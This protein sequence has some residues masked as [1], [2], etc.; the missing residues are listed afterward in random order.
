[1]L[2]YQK[3]LNGSVACVVGLA[4][5]VNMTT[6]VG[7]QNATPAPYQCATSH[8]ATPTIY[9]GLAT[10]PGISTPI[11]SDCLR[12]ALDI[13]SRAA[14]PRALRVTVTSATEQPLQDVTVTIEVR[15][16]TMD[17]GAS[18]Y[19]TIR[20]APDLF[21]VEKASMGMAGPWQV[22]VLIEQPDTTTV[23]AVFVIEMTN[24]A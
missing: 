21:E 2:R 16:L 7:S 6:A 24:P 22:T 15:H 9:H 19:E 18:S 10:P 8:A 1:M 23:Q 12:V 14:G 20:L 13:D 4:C 3:L 5:F 17:H 11:V